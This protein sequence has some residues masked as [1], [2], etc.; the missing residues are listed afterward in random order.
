MEEMKGRMEDEK[1]EGRRKME[2]LDAE[3]EELRRKIETTETEK[4]EFRLKVGIILSFNFSYW[5][6]RQCN[7]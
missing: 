5:L 2:K 3:L 7:S 1:E 6:N 4:D